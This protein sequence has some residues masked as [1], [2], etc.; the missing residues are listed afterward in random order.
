VFGKSASELEQ[1]A[2]NAFGGMAKRPYRPY[3]ASV[4]GLP[5]IEPGDTLQFGTNDIVT[6]YVLQRTFTGIQALRDEFKASGSE[7]REQNTSV[8]KEIIQLQGKTTKIKKDVE[9]VRVEVEDLETS[10][11]TRFE[12]TSQAISLEAQRAAQAEGELSGQISV[13]AGQVVLKVDTN[14]NIGYVELMGDPD[15]DM[16]QLV[17]KA[18]NISLEGYVG[19]NNGVIITED[20]KLHAVDGEF[21]GTITAST[22]RGSEIETYGND[23]YFKST[24]WDG[25]VYGV[26]QNEILVNNGVLRCSRTLYTSGGPTY[27]WETTISSDTVNTRNVICDYINGQSPVTRSDISDFVGWNSV[28]E[29]LFEDVWRRLSLLE[30]A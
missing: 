19:I 20:G 10:T 24:S 5:Y 8:N 16:T 2:R 30:N 14:G 1:I 26:Y 11:N 29:A 12:Q 9:G 15:T 13:L 18:D 22:I 21:S 23:G 28:L 6:G 7:Q 4:I 3:E 17:L 25:E 27:N